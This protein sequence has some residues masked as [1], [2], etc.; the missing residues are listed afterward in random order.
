MA[1]INQNFS[2][3]VGDDMDVDYNIGPDTTGLNLDDAQQLTWKAYAQALGVP[4][5]T[6]VLISKDKTNGIT[7][8]IRAR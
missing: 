4:N 3:F 1:D 6:T 8:M 5:K 2:I 7:I